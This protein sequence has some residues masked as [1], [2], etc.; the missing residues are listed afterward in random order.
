MRGVQQ[1]LLKGT[2]AKQL[3]PGIKVNIFSVLVV[4]ALDIPLYS[5]TIVQSIGG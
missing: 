2:H 1:N 5:V 3:G 4:S